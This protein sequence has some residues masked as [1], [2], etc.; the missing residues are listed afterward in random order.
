MD[1]D[2]DVVVHFIAP[3]EP[4][5]YDSYWRLMAPSGQMF[6]KTLRVLIQVRCFVKCSHVIVLFALYR[7]FPFCFIIK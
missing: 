3:M 2:F 5:L 1:E 6:G 7:Y 4:G